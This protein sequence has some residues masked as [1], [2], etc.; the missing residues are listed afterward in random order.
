MP[1]PSSLPS[2]TA[3][4]APSEPKCKPC[5]ACPDTRQVRDEC[6]IEFGEDS[7]KCKDLITAHQDC[8][9]EMGFKI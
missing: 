4:A 2:K 3:E 9:R 7:V 6:V 8:M 1:E 5:C